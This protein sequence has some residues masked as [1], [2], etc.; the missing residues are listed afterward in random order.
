[1]ASSSL[2]D[3]RTATRAAPSAPVVIDVARA[4]E[5]PAYE[6][7]LAVLACLMLVGAGVGVGFWASVGA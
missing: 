2:G 1:M 3:R 5:A 7:L 4:P 6:R